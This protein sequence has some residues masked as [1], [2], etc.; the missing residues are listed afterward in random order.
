MRDYQGLHV[1][2]T[3]GAGALGTTVVDAFRA[4]GAS[5]HVLDKGDVELTDED[6]VARVYATFPPMWASVQLAGGFA[7]APIVDTRLAELR[8]MHDINVVTCFLACREAVRSMRRGG[9]GGRIV[10]VAARPALAPAGG[11]IAYAAAKAAVASIT[12]S[13]AHE[14]A[15]DRI[16]VNA[17]APS[18]IDTPANRRAMPDARHDRWPKPAEIAEAILFLASPRNTLTSGVVLPVYGQA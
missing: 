18:I 13:L 4:A 15:P 3:G 5:C 12:Q 9:A 17:V 11:M 14:V 2:V 6:D 1:V 8:A 16:L 7:M 10:N